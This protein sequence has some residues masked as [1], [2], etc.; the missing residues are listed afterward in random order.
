[1]GPPH[2]RVKPSLYRMCPAVVAVVVIVVVVVVIV[3][4]YKDTYRKPSN[5][6]AN[7]LPVLITHMIRLYR[8]V[9]TQRKDRGGE[10][11][12][13][14]LIPSGEG[15]GPRMDASASPCRIFN[16]IILDVNQVPWVIDCRSACDTTLTDS[17][18]EVVLKLARD[19]VERKLVDRGGLR[20]GGKRMEGKERKGEVCQAGSATLLPREKLHYSGEKRLGQPA[21]TPTRDR[22]YPMLSWPAVNLC[23]RG[24]CLF[25]C[26]GSQ[27]RLRTIVSRQACLYWHPTCTF[28][29]QD[30]NRGGDFTINT[31]RQT[32]DVHTY[33]HTH[34]HTHTHTRP[35]I[36]TQFSHTFDIL[37]SEVNAVRM[38]LL[39]NIFADV[40]H[41]QLSF[42]QPDPVNTSLT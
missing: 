17:W 28:T 19:R 23:M 15:W 39:L 8:A 38:L 42:L 16:W 9:R 10:E 37:C 29:L 33:T 6:T 34:T 32:C 11:L 40:W 12:S 21:V 24:I 4:V 35:R 26:L 36:H 31:W 18:K 7:A 13:S 5:L 30:Y 25:V 1:M 22:V 3:R 41:H 27:K 14:Y 20:K 2:W